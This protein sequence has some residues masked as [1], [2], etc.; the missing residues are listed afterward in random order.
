MHLESFHTGTQANTIYGRPASIGV[1]S[2]DCYG[3]TP[4]PPR[5]FLVYTKECFHNPETWQGVDE[6]SFLAR[7]RECAEQ[8]LQAVT[9]SEEGMTRPHLPGTHYQVAM[10]PELDNYNFGLY[11]Q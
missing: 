9:Q 1:C 7:A 3:N 2:R 4:Q 11:F 5:H 10:V 8:S 6:E